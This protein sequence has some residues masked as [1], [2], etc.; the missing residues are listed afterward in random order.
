[1]NR[2]TYTLNPMQQLRQEFVEP[3]AR[4][5]GG[6]VGTFSAPAS[7]WWQATGFFL[8]LALFGLQFYPAIA[9]VV[10]W[11]VHR[12]KHDRYAFMFELMFMLGGFGFMPF[13]L[14][15]KSSDVALALSLCAIFMLRRSRLTSRIMWLT[16]AYFAALILIATTSEETMRTQFLTM[17]TYF[18]FI[19]FLL[20]LAVFANR[21]FEFPRFIHT[22]VLHML[23][24]SAFYVLDTFVLRG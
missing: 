2:Q 18:T 15:F 23:I 19:A 16:L 9:L 21:E 22:V 8:C 24:M 17:R 7:E 3:V 11:L 20:P 14:P 4:D 6:R 5:E 10:M 13:S 1:M 12:Y